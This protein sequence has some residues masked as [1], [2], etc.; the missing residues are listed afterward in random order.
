M[1]SSIRKFSKSFLGKIVIG[2]IAIAFVA[3]FGMGGSFSGKQ[4]IVAEINSDKI[5]SQE[6]VTYLQRVGITK[7]DIEMAGGKS[8][9]IQKVLMN[10]ISEEIISMESKKKGVQLSEKSLFEKLIDDKKF[11]KDGKF[12]QTKYEKFMLSNGLTKPYYENL[13]RETEVKDQLLNFYSG[14]IKLPVFVINDLYKKENRVIK[15]NYISLTEVYGKEQI[16]QIQIKDYYEKN[17]SSFN[18]V[19]KKFKY[20]KLSPETLIGKKVFD[21][22]FFKKIDEI[23]N[24]ILDGKG[25][26]EITAENRSGIQ[27]VDFINIK[28]IKEDGSA[29]KS[30]DNKSFNEIFKI[31]DKNS[32]KFINSDN[33]YY[34][35]QII[36][37]KTKM[38]TLEN[39]DLKKMIE[40]QI[41]VLSQIEKIGKLIGDI[42]DQKFFEKDMVELSKKNNI[43]INSITIKNI[44][45]DSKFSRK[46]LKNIYQFNKGQIFVMP[47]EKENYLVKIVDEDNPKIDINSDKYKVYVKKANAQYI[48]KIYKSYDKY[49][50]ANYK[51]DIKSTVLKR[52]ENSFWWN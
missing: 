24:A 36:E 42:N 4:N 38:L 28:K 6:F 21:E 19:Y 12:S 10:Y 27:N 30:I 2:L 22:E 7:D 52:I 48:G 49:I 17:K 46:L 8:E 37:S 32:P 35:V 16:S 13:V 1:L 18:Q 50:N 31:E 40:S 43:P 5:S 9:L 20:L 15:I 41:K 3:G 14:G 47:G 39:K 45:D 25:F 23:E 34:L 33:N 26:E 51:I 11:K 44:T 29:F